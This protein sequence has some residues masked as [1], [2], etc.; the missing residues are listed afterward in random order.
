MNSFFAV[1]LGGAIGVMSRHWLNIILTKNFPSHIPI[2]TLSVNLIGGFFVGVF[3]ALSI[4]FHWSNT[5]KLILITGVLGG[6][7][8]Y[9]TFAIETMFLLEK[10]Y[11]YGFLNIFYN[12]V[13]ALV[14]C[15]VGF[16]V[17]ETLLN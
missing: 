9:S 14:L 11:L 6:L 7:T 15:F 13:G 2:A 12:L 5:A 8:T 3:V 4:Y 17:V 16:K 10:S 1:A